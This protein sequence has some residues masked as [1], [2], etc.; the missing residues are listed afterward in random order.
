ML[1]LPSG[2][3]MRTDSDKETLIK[4]L[5]KMPIIQIACKN[6]GISR[7]TY[8]RWHKWD[9]K[10][11]NKA[12]KALRSGRNFIND[13]AESQLINQIRNG[14]MT[15]IIFWL[16]NNHKIYG[17]KDPNDFKVEDNPVPSPEVIEQ[18]DRLM[19]LNSS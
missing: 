3:K 2:I 17:K 19:E 12:D 5:K 16:K 4:Q 1:E 6:V 7:A 11:A 13:V 10:F 9:Y 15:A 18:I 8:Y 14:H